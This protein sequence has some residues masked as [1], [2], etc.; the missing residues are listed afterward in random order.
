ML[1]KYFKSGSFESF[2]RQLNFYG[3]KRVKGGSR[4]RFKHPLFHRNNKEEYHLIKRQSK[5]KVKQVLCNND[6]ESES[7]WEIEDLEN[8]DLLLDKHDSEIKQL[9]QNNEELQEQIKMKEKELFEMEN[10]LDFILKNLKDTQKIKSRCKGCCSHH[11][12]NDY[13]NELSNTIPFEK[14]ELKTVINQ[15]MRAINNKKQTD[16]NNSIIDR[17]GIVLDKFE[18]IKTNSTVK[19][20]LCTSQKHIS[21]QFK[22]SYL[23]PQRLTEFKSYRFEDIDDLNFSTNRLPEN[24]EDSDISFNLPLI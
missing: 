19:E 13:E 4:I 2:K 20:S 24:F 18:S 21:K 8:E 9:K 6:G 14:E 10:D 17:L 7:C 23:F 12:V 22:K 1:P 5:S 3:F 11:Q 15:M 16:C